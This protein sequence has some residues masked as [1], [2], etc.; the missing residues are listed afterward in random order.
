MYFYIPFKGKK[1]YI[2]NLFKN[3]TILITNPNHPI[4]KSILLYLSSEF[5]KEIR[6]ILIGKHPAYLNQLKKY[7]ID[8]KDYR[9]ERENYVLS[10]CIDPANY[11]HMKKAFKIIK[12]KWDSIDFIFHFEDYYYD[13]NLKDYPVH[14]VK[15]LFQRNILSLFNIIKLQSIFLEKKIPIL[16]FINQNQKN[17]YYYLKKSIFEYIRHLKIPIST[18]LIPDSLYINFNKSE[19]KKKFKN[20]NL[21]EKEIEKILIYFIKNKM[22]INL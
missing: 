17:L 15:Y 8:K 21:T 12:D 5:K 6:L 4:G 14:N 3:K 20:S 10:F 18:I 16:T 1:S 11:K 2:K 9:K 19:I 13:S 7:I 22:Y